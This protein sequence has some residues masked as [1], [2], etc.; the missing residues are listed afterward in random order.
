MSG[1]EIEREALVTKLDESLHRGRE[2]VDGLV[3]S[4][5]GAGLVEE[6]GENVAASESGRELHARIGGRAQEI[7]SRLW[8]DLPDEDLEVAGR[9]LGIV[10]DRARA[11]LA[12]L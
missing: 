1:D 3:D 6:R 9:V 10:L 11:E 8:G 7:T 4:L 5:I 12:Q 2:A